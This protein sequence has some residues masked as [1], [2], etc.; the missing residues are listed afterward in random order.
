MRAAVVAVCIV[1]LAACGGSDE[2]SSTSPEA[3]PR[4]ASRALALARADDRLRDLVGGAQYHL[5]EARE[6]RVHEA[7]VGVELALRLRS[8]IARSGDWP[9]AHPLNPGAKPPYRMEELT[10]SARDV[11][12]LV[13]RVDLTRKRVAGIEP[14]PGAAVECQ[15]EAH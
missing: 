9:V 2:T 6:W 10:Y 4:D 15:P 5:A 12:T 3:R 8:A 7:K 13:V 11:T 14:G 1:L